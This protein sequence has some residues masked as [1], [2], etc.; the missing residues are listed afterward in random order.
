MKI[1]N[2]VKYE[3]ARDLRT[4]GKT[5]KEIANITESGYNTI[6]RWVG[7]IQLTKEQHKTIYSKSV[8]VLRKNSWTGKKIE[9]EEARRLRKEEGMS[10]GKISKVLKVSKG[11][12]SV[13]VRDI[14]LTEKQKMRLKQ[15]Q[16][17]NGGKTL[18]SLKCLERRQ[19]YQENGRAKARCGDIQY[20]S[21]CMLYWAEGSK[22]R[23]TIGFS[24]SDIEMCKFF[25][26]FLIESCGVDKEKINIY[27]KCYLNNGLSQDD[28][29]IYWLKN[30]NLD[31][32]NLRKTFIWTPKEDR[33]KKIGKL[34]YGVCT[35]NVNNTRLIQ[36]IY[37]S[38]QEYIGF[39]NEKW[40][41]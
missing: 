38:I 17:D 31:R 39:N 30:L 13:W 4:R 14:T 6:R 12:V 28:I 36:E 21:G 23:N 11:S 18:L 2:L 3:C 33:G 1:R 9:Q 25:I 10:V 20:I 8:A 34:P 24:N 32:I 22:Q 29:E 35:I 15:N 37:G 5:I 19:Q 26:K 27:I 7:D 40:V 16:K 41:K